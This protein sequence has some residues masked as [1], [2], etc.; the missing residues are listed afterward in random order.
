MDKSV[1]A[2]HLA[3][4]DHAKNVTFHSSFW[5]ASKMSS[6]SNSVVA[7]LDSRAT[8]HYL[9]KK[10]AHLLKNRSR[11][12]NGPSV[13][14]PDSSETT[15]DKDGYLPLPS[16]LSLKELQIPLW[17]KLEN[18][19]ITDAKFFLQ[20]ILPWLQKMVKYF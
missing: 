16:Q 5:D 1:A 4:T 12:K 3:M 7:K 19:A 20:K 11:I 10:D 2:S 6:Q 14:L 9:Q 18:Y 17:S 13:Q 8:G 15:S